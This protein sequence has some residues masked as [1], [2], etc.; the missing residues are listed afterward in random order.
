LL[1]N[2]ITAVQPFKMHLPTLVFVVGAVSTANA[3]QV[4]GTADT[5]G[6]RG[7]TRDNGIEAFLGIRY[8]QD[9]G[10]ENRFKPPRL[11]VPPTGSIIDATQPGLACPQLLGQRNAPL[12]LVNITEVSEDCLNLNIVRP[13]LDDS[14]E[15]L[16]VMVWIHG[17]SFW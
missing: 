5:V 2:L 10:G 16:P 4:G 8:A 14:S 6:Y 11:Y 3:L 7:I 1:L 17:G 15:K 9:T 13:A 12:A